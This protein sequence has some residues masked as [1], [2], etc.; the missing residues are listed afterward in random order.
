MHHGCTIAWCG[1]Q[2]DVNRSP[3]LLGLEAPMALDE[4][5][6]PFQ[7]QVMVQFQPNAREPITGLAGTFTSAT[8]ARFQFTPIAA[9][10]EAIE[11]AIASVVDS[12]STD[13]SAAAPG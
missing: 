13:P 8:G 11:T 1:W 10:S 6:R 5:G 4:S 3:A 12:S 2:W 7:G 9:S